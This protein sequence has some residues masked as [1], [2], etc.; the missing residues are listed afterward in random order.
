[1][2]FMKKEVQDAKEQLPQH[3]RKKLLEVQVRVEEATKVYERAIKRNF[4][5]A[6][7]A[8]SARKS[9]QHAIHASVETCEEHI[10]LISL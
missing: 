5:I 1:M 7:K 10:I 2:Y 8:R 3:Y 4:R 9:I 6:K